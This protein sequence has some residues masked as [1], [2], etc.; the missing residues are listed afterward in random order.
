VFGV[1]AMSESALIKKPEPDSK[2]YAYAIVKGAIS[3][4][5]LPILPGVAAEVMSLILASPL[6]KRQD[7]WI[8]SIANGLVELQERID[9]FKLEDL[10]KNESFVSCVLHSTQAAIRTHQEEKLIALQNAVLNSALPNAPEDDLQLIFINWIGEFT[11]W[12]LRVLKLFDSPTKWAEENNTQFPTSWYMGGIDQVLGFAYPEIVKDET[13][14]HQIFSDL[15]SKG[16][17]GLSS[18]MMSARG[19]LESRT[20][21][22]G[23]RFLRFISSP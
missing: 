11:T 20:S 1:T 3:S 10:S 23:K 6:S 12:H 9:G 13:I 19:M 22:M 14:Y 21:T 4:I 18:G 16:L 8:T 15:N 17:A 7:E 2:D 5:P